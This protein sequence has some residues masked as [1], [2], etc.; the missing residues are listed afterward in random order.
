[1][2]ITWYANVKTYGNDALI[3][4]FTFYHGKKHITIFTR[5]P[6]NDCIVNEQLRNGF[7]VFCLTVYVQ[8][9]NGGQCSKVNSVVSF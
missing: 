1:M 5:I 8:L 6:L 4:T 2:N 7:T 9:P 3:K